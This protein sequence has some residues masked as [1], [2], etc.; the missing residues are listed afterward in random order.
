MESSALQQVL[1]RTPQPRFVAAHVTPGPRPDVDQ[2]GQAARRVLVVLAP[3]FRV[4]AQVRE[5]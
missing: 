1:Q 4:L 3:R 5:V 2:D